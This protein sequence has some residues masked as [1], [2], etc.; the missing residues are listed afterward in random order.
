MAVHAPMPGANRAAAWH[1][2]R[3]CGG[4]R[5]WTRTGLRSGAV[6]AKQLSASRLPMWLFVCWLSGCAAQWTV[7]LTSEPPGAEVVSRDTAVGR[8]P[9]KL[10]VGNQDVG[11]KFTFRKEGYAD[12]VCYLNPGSNPSWGTLGKSLY[13]FTTGA[14]YEIH[15]KLR[16]T[17]EK[18]GRGGGAQE[19]RD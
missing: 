19:D 13:T 12:E 14:P 15:V 6:L 16:P 17:V 7:L 9:L 10:P 5:E 1:R 8:P 11:R 3:V 18:E 4:V 2:S